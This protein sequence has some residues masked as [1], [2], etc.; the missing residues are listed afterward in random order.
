[1]NLFDVIGPIMIGPSSSHTAGAVRLGRLARSLLGEAP[2]KAVIGLH[3]S[4]ASTGRGHGTDR[5]LIAGLLGWRTDDASL[6]NSFAA[7]AQSGLSFQFETVNLGAEAHPNSVAFALKGKDGAE[8]QTVGCS[9][10][11]GR[12]KITEIN[13]FPLELAGELASLITVHHDR[14][15]VIHAVTGVLAS[16]AVNIA[17]MRVSRSKKGSL[18]AMVIETDSEIPAEMVKSVAALPQILSVRALLPISD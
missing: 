18:A 10:G 16:H 5:A 3:G 9:L 4:F 2:S 7:A 13:A 6:P 12:V 1:M 14:P 11:G 8:L 17:E 15:G